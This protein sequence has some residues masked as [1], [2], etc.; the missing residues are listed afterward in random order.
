[1]YRGILAGMGYALAVLGAGNMGNAVLRAALAGGLAPAAGIVVAEPDA[2]K[3]ERAAELGV[4][5][6]ADPAAAATEVDAVGII[7]L[8][9]KPQV[10]HDVAGLIRG[11]VGRRLVVSVMAGVR[12][13]TIQA[14]CGGE[15]RVIRL[16]PNLAATVGESM[17]ALSVGP[18]ATR[19]DAAWAE[20]LCE[21]MGKVVTLPEEL[22]DVH[23]ALAG[24]GP[25]YLFYMAEAMTRAGVDLGLSPADADA[26]TRQ[27]LFGAAKL[28][29]G[30]R[31]RSPS[32]WRRAVTSKGGTTEAACRVLDD[33][34]V[35][36]A[37]V[38]AVRA[39]T[40]RGAALA[41]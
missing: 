31:G 17:T 19:A 5:I 3:A 25:A 4:R 41:R 15:C 38:G 36:E 34:G 22:L 28:L 24:S 9:V 20:R 37:F 7:L 33:R 10:F 6:T 18:A 11:V 35:M 8:A 13:D 30:D 23:T 1:M 39:G 16:M 32:D 14:A 21:A 26:I 12:S 40:A 2:A 27:T 29:A